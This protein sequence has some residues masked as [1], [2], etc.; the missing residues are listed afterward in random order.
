M[1]SKPGLARCL[2]MSLG[3]TC[4]LPRWC[5]AYRRREL[6]SGFGAERG[7]LSPR[8]RGRPVGWLWPAVVRGRETPKRLI[9]E[10]PSTDEGHRGGPP[11][12]SDDAR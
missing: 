5:P 4:L 11:R 9:R 1:T 12:G 10:G 6:G 8:A 7:N 3:E 2:G